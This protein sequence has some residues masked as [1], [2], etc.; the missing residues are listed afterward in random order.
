MISCKAT[1]TYGKYGEIQPYKDQ[2]CTMKSD[3]HK[4]KMKTDWENKNNS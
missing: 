2:T 4:I 3:I 1:V